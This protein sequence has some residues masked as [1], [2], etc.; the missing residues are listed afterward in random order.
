MSCLIK[1]DARRAEFHGKG[2][3]AVGGRDSAA[4][5][6]GSDDARISGN[7]A[8]TFVAQVGDIQIARAIQIQIIRAMQRS[9]AGR[10]AIAAEELRSRA[11]DGGNDAG[12]GRDFADFMRTLVNNVNVARRVNRQV[13]RVFESRLGRRAAIA[14]G[15]ARRAESIAGEGRDNACLRVNFADPLAAQLGDVKVARAVVFDVYGIAEA[16]L[17]GRAAIAIAGVAQRNAAAVADNSVD[18]PVRRNPAHA[19]LAVINDNQVSRRVKGDFRRLD[20]PGLCG[21]AAVAKFRRTARARNNRQQAG[22]RIY[23]QHTIAAAEIE[24]ARRIH[25]H[26]RRDT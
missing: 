7:A 16:S 24:I 19:V 23:L 2:R 4:S 13:R 3:G 21:G 1:C 17:N 26:S 6:D 25:R 15:A 9:G 22:A 14:A 8:H 5:R 20:Q 10:A 18:N 12:A 11:G